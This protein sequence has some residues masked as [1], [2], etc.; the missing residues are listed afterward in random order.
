M[1][2][3]ELPDG[4]QVYGDTSWRGKCPTEDREQATFF[5]RLR[6]QYPKQ[7]GATGLHIKNEGKRHHRQMSKT[8]AG[9]GF[10]KGASDIVIP[11]APT[12]VCEMKRKDHTQS[13]WQDGQ[14]DYLEAAH[15]QGAFVCVALG[16]D[17]AWEGFKAYLKEHYV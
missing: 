5:A 2:F 12:F 4:V 6:A 10:I 8:R 1:K 11:G 13:R 15:W 16:C 9:G 14:V 3:N 17:A 7:W